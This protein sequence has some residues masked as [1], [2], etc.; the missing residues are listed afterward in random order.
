MVWVTGFTGKLNDGSQVK[1]TH[2]H[3]LIFVNKHVESKNESTIYFLRYW[4]QKGWNWLHSPNIFPNF[5]V[6]RCDTFRTS[7]MRDW[8]QTKRQTDRTSSSFKA[9]FPLHR[10]GA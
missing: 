8:R 3:D 5:H 2:C 4:F 1:N 7:F 9:L 6:D 10:V